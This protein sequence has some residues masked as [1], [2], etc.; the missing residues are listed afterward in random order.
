MFYAKE[1]TLIHQK[2]DDP[3]RRDRTFP[4]DDNFNF[5]IKNS[6]RK[7]HKQ[8]LFRVKNKNSNNTGL[9]FFTISK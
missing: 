7:H 3:T 8:A 9:R 1:F 6:Q 5:L 2:C 4:D